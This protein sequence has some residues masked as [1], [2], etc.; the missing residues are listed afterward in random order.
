MKKQY[1]FVVAVIL[2]TFCL[3]IAVAE[4]WTP[5]LAEDGWTY[6]GYT[7]GGITFAVP[8]DYESF[9]ISKD[10]AEDGIV[11]MGEMKNLHCKCVFFSWKI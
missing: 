2:T 4:D 10:D 5:L 8:K 7:Y 3:S 1:M 11:I 6:I 9:N